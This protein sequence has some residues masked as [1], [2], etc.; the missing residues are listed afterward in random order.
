MMHT[1]KRM[2]ID[3][4]SFIFL[5]CCYFLI[6]STIF[7]LLF[8]V[9]DPD[10]YGTLGISFKTLFIAFIGE[11]FYFDEYPNYAMSYQILIIVHIFLSHIFL[12]NYLIAI[13]STVYSYMN[14][15]GEFEFRVNKYNFIEKYSIPMLEPG[16]KELV[17]HPPPV[18]FFTIPL[19]F[20][21]FSR[22]CINSI[23][24]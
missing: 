21:V 19:Y 2:L 13:L 15:V 23:G 12:M 1:L 16:Y 24:P 14:E 9:P 4:M 22:T 7:T 18:N 5:S 20:G 3:T 10:D 11:Y 17:V 6:M 8:Q